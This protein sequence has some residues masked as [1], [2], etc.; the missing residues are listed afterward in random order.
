MRFSTGS[1]LCFSVEAFI[2]Q[3][4][5]VTSSADPVLP[6]QFCP[7]H[8]VTSH[9]P[10]GNA[11]AN[12]EL[13]RHWIAFASLL[14][15]C[16]SSSLVLFTYSWLHWVDSSRLSSFAVFVLFLIIVIYLFLAAL[17]LR[18]CARAF[19]SCGEQG[20]ALSSRCT[21]FSLL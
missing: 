19:S 3:A 8:H 4:R 17:G 6:T 18:C 15:E 16:L 21:G 1:P 9:Q 10:R 7:P 2:G 14:S 5:S 13:S 20:A 11:G 12:P